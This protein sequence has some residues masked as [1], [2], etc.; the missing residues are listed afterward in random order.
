MI[1]PLSLSH[2]IGFTVVVLIAAF[3]TGYMAGRNHGRVATLEAAV[4]AHQTRERINYETENM[5]AAALCLALGGLPI[6]C[7]DIMRGL[8]EAAKG[9]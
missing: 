5:D 2:K 3:S 1:L 7:T 6:E 9:E 4:K 8:A